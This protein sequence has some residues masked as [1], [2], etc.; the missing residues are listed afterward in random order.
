MP[1]P[2][3]GL[4]LVS[5]IDSMDP[6]SAL[7]LVNVFP[8]AGGPTVRLG[9]EQFA[10][11]GTA[12]PIYFMHEYPL[13]GG[14]AQLIAAQTT[15][16]YSID[17]D[18]AVT[19]I[20]KVGGYLSGNWNK[21]L[22]AGNI[23]LANNGGDVP[24]VYTGTGLAA[25]ISTGGG[26][27]SASDLINVASYRERLYWVERNTCKVW[28]NTTAG[29]NFVAG[30]PVLTSYDFQYIFRRGGFLLFTGSFTNQ[31]NVTSQDLFMAVSSEGEV[32]LYSGFSPSDPEW[33]L[34]AHFMI[35][36]PLGPRAFVIVNQEILIIT[37]QGIVPVSALFSASPQEA[38]DTVSRPINPLITQYAT[39]VSLSERWNGFFWTAGRRI[40]ITLP[41]SG[42]TATLLVYSMD[43][44]A[45]TQVALLVG[46]H[47]TS[48]CKFL[49]L[50]FHGSS[51]GIIY[52]GET[53]YADAAVSG[54]GQSIA[55]S[56]R[57]AFSFY[58]TRGNYKAFKD[59]RPLMRGKRGLTLNLGLDTDFKRASTVTTVTTSP[60]LFT[61][62][63]SPWGSPWSADVDYVFDRFATKGQGHC[64][65]IRFGGSIKNS[66]LQL[67][68][69]EIRYDLGGQV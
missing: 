6:A 57:M 7:E 10:D 1:P 67:F 49:D 61:A 42:T 52:Q 58:G 9:Y 45:W 14:T 65:A 50:P 64:A 30:S 19:N 63:G 46:A 43:T 32:V 21:E 47:C 25:N 31:K 24:Q 66:P 62:W 40:Y 20:S 38:Q 51:T 8:G 15:A 11:L 27:Y 39:Q 33:T 60:G 2:S 44:K 55:F 41:D 56:G 4:D 12:S 16:L 5:P 29:T 28:Y 22:F 3:L 35:G 18:G 53:G 69:F 34:V 36:K 23:Y 26:G 54:D 68:G 37:Q 17:D 13:Q 48:N 59:I